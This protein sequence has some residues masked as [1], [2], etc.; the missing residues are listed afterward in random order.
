MSQHFRHVE[1]TKLEDETFLNVPTPFIDA[2][3]S[4]LKAN[5]KYVAYGG[6]IENK[7]HLVV[8]NLLLKDANDIII[9]GV[10]PRSFEDSPICS[11]EFS[12]YND[13][14]I[15]AGNENGTVYTI[16]IPKDNNGENAT[17]LGDSSQVHKSATKIIK[18]HPSC[19]SIIATTGDDCNL[20]VLEIS[21]LGSPYFNF[22][23]FGQNHP[24]DMQWN[25]DGSQMALT[26]NDGF[27]RLFD[28]RTSKEKPM[29]TKTFE[30]LY[31]AGY[32]QYDDL[33]YLVNQA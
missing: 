25:Y 30:N 3:G 8:K 21:K 27:I 20:N 29:K 28:P 6:L 19:A 33:L 2:H 9:N 31:K 13:S 12:H 1:A 10:K 11:L 16:C 18:F 4:L 26:T 15:V 17:L 24:F 5:G 32:V 22:N 14:L 7:Q 23:K